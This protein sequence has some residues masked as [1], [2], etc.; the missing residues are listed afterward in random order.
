MSYNMKFILLLSYV[1]LGAKLCLLHDF[2]WYDRSTCFI[3]LKSGRLVPFLWKNILT[4]EGATNEFIV[5][6][7]SVRNISRPKTEVKILFH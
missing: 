4:Y 3:N 1:G 2:G 6:E 7:E 5:S